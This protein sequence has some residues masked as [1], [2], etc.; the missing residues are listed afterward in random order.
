MAA[1]RRVASGTPR[2]SLSGAVRYVACRIVD[3]ADRLH[4]RLD[5][6][7]L[8]QRRDDEQLQAQLAKSS[9]A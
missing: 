3:E 4:V 7:N 5:D 9:S 1:V 2:S 6:M 8:L